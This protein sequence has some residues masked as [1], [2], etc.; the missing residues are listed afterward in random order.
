MQ[1]QLDL[2]TS[3]MCILAT[4]NCRCER[5]PPQ[6]YSKQMNIHSS[7][8]EYAYLDDHL[9]LSS[10]TLEDHLDKL[11]KVLQHLQTKGCL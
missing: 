1:L 3:G 9:I 11:G 2:R 10:S 5:Q 8:L 7:D 4:A 6:M